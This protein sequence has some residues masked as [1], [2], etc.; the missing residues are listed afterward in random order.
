VIVRPI[1]DA[2]LDLAWN[3]L[4]W[5]RDLTQPLETMRKSEAYMKDHPARGRGTVTLPEMRRGGVAVCLG[6][7]LARAKQD[8]CP[9]GGF[10]RRELD[11]RSQIVAHSVGC[12]Q[13]AYYQ[14]LDRQGH[15]KM[16]K[17]GPDLSRHWNAWKTSPA[18]TPLGL[19]L[20]M[21]GADPIVEPD[22]IELWWAQGLRCVGLA[23]Y[24]KCHYAMGTGSMG[25]LTAKGRQLLK[26]MQELG[27]ILDLTHCSE[28]GFFEALELFSGPVLASHNMCQALVP[29]DR[30]FSDEQIRALFARGA[31]IGAACDAWMLYPGWQIGQTDREVVSLESI[32]DHICQ[33]AGNARHT[34][35]GTD[36]DGG[37][38]TEQCP[39][40]LNSIADLQKL[41]LMLGK[42]GYNDA[43]INAIFC[44]NWL[45]FF[46]Q[47]LP[48]N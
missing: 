11:Y 48:K 19:I 5:N 30:Q 28:P 1:I 20:A 37:Y 46:S 43:D 26:I 33:L 21:E 8:V 44:G 34:A 42:R 18:D 29:G 41:D 36:L 39:R 22:Q 31:V 7:I 4:Q 24:A 9:V 45:R 2:H 32:C 10:D 23:H 14:E 3:A 17:S 15:I 38:G 40:D 35:I 16:L 25:P 13:V 27:M 6:T 12:A 47:A